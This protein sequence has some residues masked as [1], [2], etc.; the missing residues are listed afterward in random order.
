ME[1]VNSVSKYFVDWQSR[2][3]YLALQDKR[4]KDVEK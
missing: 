2:S 4:K 3:T 1:F